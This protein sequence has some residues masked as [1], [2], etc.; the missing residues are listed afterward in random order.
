MKL[1][2]FFRWVIQGPNNFQLKRSL[3]RCISVQWILLKVRQIKNKETLRWSTAEMPQQLAVGLAVHKAVQSKA[4]I[5]MLH[6]F[7]M[8]ADKNRI[9]RAI[10][11]AR[12]KCSLESVWFRIMLFTANS[13]NV[14][15]GFVAYWIPRPKC[16]MDWSIMTC[17]R[18]RCV[19]E[20]EIMVDCQGFPDIYLWVLESQNRRKHTSISM[21]NALRSKG[22]AKYNMQ[23]NLRQRFLN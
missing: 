2:S 4:L 18:L 17:V 20:T 12:T 19:A 16:I 5:N 13:K 21:Q 3:M 14:V 9:L 6:G 7:G 22:N 10:G 15:L 1:Y 11:A 8:L 23:Q